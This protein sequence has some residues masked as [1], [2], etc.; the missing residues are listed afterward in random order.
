M[1]GSDK[2]DT[3]AAPAG[4]T[5]PFTG[6]GRYIPEGESLDKVWIAITFSKFSLKRPKCYGH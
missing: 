5:D 1:P 3:S 4:M 6:G 2:M